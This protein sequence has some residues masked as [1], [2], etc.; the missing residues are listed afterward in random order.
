M[1]YNN[2][3]KKTIKQNLFYGYISSKGRNSSGRICVHHRGGG[4][5]RKFISIDFYGRINSI[6]KILKIYKFALRSAYIGSIIYNNG[7]VNQIILS[8]KVKISDLIYRGTFIDDKV[9]LGEGVTLPLC[10]MNLFTT[11]HCIELYP[12]KGVQLLRSAGTF[13]TVSSK[14]E[15]KVSLKLNNGTNIILSENCISSFGVVS[16]PEHRIYNFKR[17]GFKRGLGIRPTVR[18]VAMNPCDHP[19]GGGEGKKSPP[20]AARSPWGWLTKGRPTV[21]F[22]AKRFKKVKRVR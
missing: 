21:I 20:A 8:D 17:A 19:H 9:I 6:G 2:L 11:V 3:I 22:G 1:F 14:I 16:N 15:D 10:Y 12:Y 18:G 5:K 7:L 4:K 13:A